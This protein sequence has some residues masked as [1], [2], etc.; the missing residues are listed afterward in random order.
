MSTCLL[1]CIRYD[2]FGIKIYR[3]AYYTQKFTSVFGYIYIDIYIY[4]STT[5][6]CYMYMHLNL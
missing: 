1:R 4:L 6:T 2:T 5:S 3:N